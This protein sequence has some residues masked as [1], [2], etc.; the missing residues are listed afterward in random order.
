VI[1]T[2]KCPECQSEHDSEHSMLTMLLDE[3]CEE[4]GAM[5]QLVI[6]GGSGFVLRGRG[7]ASDGYATPP[8]GSIPR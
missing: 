3:P 8:P 6:T 5:A 1:Y 2:Y 7:W 4:C